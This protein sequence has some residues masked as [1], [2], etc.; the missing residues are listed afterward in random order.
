MYH[1]TGV[2]RVVCFVVCL[3]N[4]LAALTLGLGLFN[5]DVFTMNVFQTTLSALVMPLKIAFL[6]SGVLGLLSLFCKCKSC[7]A[8]HHG[9]HKD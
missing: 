2:G 8:R 6:I 7:D 9:H 1:H 3:L 5:I 4:S